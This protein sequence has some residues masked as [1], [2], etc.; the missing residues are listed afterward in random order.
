MRSS[1]AVILFC[2]LLTGVSCQSQQPAE[3]LDAQAFH[4]KLKTT[5]GA[6]VIDV[7]TP[8]E[9][10]EGALDAAVNID[11]RDE[12]FKT[13]IN[14]LDKSKT[15]FVYCLSGGRSGA[16]ATYMRSNGFTHV[17]DMKG[18][19]LSWRKNNLPLVSKSTN[20]DG[21]KISAEEYQHLIGSDSIV[22]I[23]FY[24]PWCAPCKEMEPMLAELT[25]E[26]AGKVK[27]IRLNIDENK[28]LAKQLSVE[29]IP[30]FK[31]FRKGKEVWM[32]KGALKKA[33]LIA[34][35]GGRI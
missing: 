10:E 17:I 8:G 32:H 16:A 28:Q 4:D 27:I 24:A 12:Q 30:I 13:S 15:Y 34:V 2:C 35:I 9:F 7:R 33:D 21:D 31:L 23:D 11:Y 19:I 29:E 6:V 18:G 22:L 14:A 26:Y 25:Q 5:T 20:S 3:K 1:V